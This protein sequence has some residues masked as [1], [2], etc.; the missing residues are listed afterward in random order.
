MNCR[1][2]GV[3]LEP[4]EEQVNAAVDGILESSLRDA[5]QHGGVCPLCGHS[6]DVPYT[7]RPPVLFL[8][9]MACLVSGAVAITVY[10]TG[11]VTRRQA[12]VDA[13]LAKLNASP[14][15]VRLLGTP[16]RMRSGIQGEVRQDETG[17]QEARLTIPVHG[18]AAD[19]VARVAAGRATGPWTF[20]TFEVVVEKEHK[21]VDLIAGKVVVLDEN[22]YVETHLLPAA[23]AEIGNRD[24]PA[25]TIDATY[26]CVYATVGRTPSAPQLGSC[27]L[28][29]A[30]GAPVDRMEA[31]L[32]YSRFVLRETDLYLNDGFQVPLTR[33]YS[34][35]D[36][37]HPNP[38]HAFGRNTNHPYD[39]APVGTRNPYTYQMLV[40][41][42]GDFVYFPRI[43]QGSGYADAVYQQSESGG[44]FYKATQRWNGDGWTTTLANGDEIVFPESY[45]AKNMAQ[46]SPVELRNARG[47]R[48]QLI[49]NGRR[50]LEEILTP[51]GHWIKFQYDAQSRIVYASDDARNWAKY[52]YTAD[53]MLESAVLSTGRERH[54]LYDGDRMVAVTDEKGQ[55]LVINNY[56]GHDLVRQQFPDG[57][58]VSYGYHVSVNGKYRAVSNVTLPD[59]TSRDVPLAR[60]IP[61]YISKE[62]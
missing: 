43:S 15:V 53:G 51:H 40:L 9:L 60:F 1:G 26:P 41:E 5:E 28:G 10:E 58:V 38:V 32:R 4:S 21:K 59:G 56:E 54:F 12:V 30:P 57:S 27:P 39:I 14:E 6:K 18:S 35:M 45:S 48:L 34:S 13:A 3:A 2:C 44:R 42:D 62:H 19:G 61:N 49:R 47:D 55:T 52:A 8:L 29:A 11:K 20:S 25:P 24:V 16:I 22:A 33:T 36:W 50:D 46:G 7:H 37:L 31:D 23:Q 17:W